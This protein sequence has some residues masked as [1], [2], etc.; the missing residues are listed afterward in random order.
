MKLYKFTHKKNYFLALAC[1]LPYI[2]TNLRLNFGVGLFSFLDMGPTSLFLDNAFCLI[3]SL[4]FIAVVIPSRRNFLIF[5]VVAFM[6][7]FTM[8]VMRSA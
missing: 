4:I 5:A 1:I 2:L 7:I 3:P 8:P 6:A